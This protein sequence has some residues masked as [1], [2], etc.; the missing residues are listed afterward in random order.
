MAEG[1]L[2]L[3]RRTQAQENERVRESPSSAVEGH[4]LSPGSTLHTLDLILTE[5]SVK[6]KGASVKMKGA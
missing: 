4:K 6:M 1:L 2:R 3:Q 5:I